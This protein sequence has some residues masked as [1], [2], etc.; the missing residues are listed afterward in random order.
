MHRRRIERLNEQLKRELM[1]MLR[2]DL[3]DPRVALVTVT[4]VETT[5]DLYHARVYVTALGGEEERQESLAGL[6]AARVVLRGELGRRLHIRR[7]PE[8]DF[9]WDET[10]EHARRIESLLAQVRPPEEAPEPDGRGEP[11]DG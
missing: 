4:A 6:R 7:V 11:G 5:P 1:D 10:L 2:R 9:V 3:G 8:L